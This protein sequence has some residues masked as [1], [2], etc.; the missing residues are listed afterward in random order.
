MIVQVLR[1][2]RWE[3]FKLR[4]RWM[5]WVPLGRRP[6]G[7]PG[8]PVA[9]LRCVRERGRPRTSSYPGR[10]GAPIVTISCADILDG[11]ADAKVEMV[12]EEFREDARERIEQR[13][14]RGNCPSVI[15][16][17]VRADRGG[18]GA[19]SGVLRPSGWARQ[20]Y[21]SRPF[22]RCSPCHGPGSVGAWHRVRLGHPANG[23]D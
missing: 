11:T 21:R 14:E 18:P 17:I 6:I 7:R 10:G 20:Q 19:S 22:H 12:I 1:L 4:K 3:L 15:E 9:L 8:H 13:R 2:T 16:Q 5:P 23:A